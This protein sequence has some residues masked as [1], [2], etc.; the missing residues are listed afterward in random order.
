M[1]T[2]TTQCTITTSEEKTGVSDVLQMI[3]YVIVSWPLEH[4][5]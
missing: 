4:M 5:C 2:I 1:A 3:L